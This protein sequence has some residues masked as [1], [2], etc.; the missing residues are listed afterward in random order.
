MTQH[1][2][3]LVRLALALHL[4]LEPDTITIAARLEDDLGLDALDLVLVL[5]RLEE[6]GEA[7]LP[8]A[9]LE[10]AETVADLVDLV[11]AWASGPRTERTP[12]IPPSPPSAVYA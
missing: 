8:V 4:D 11:D 12:S 6:L 5:L 3:D 1:G 2:F 7:E 10:N 9:D